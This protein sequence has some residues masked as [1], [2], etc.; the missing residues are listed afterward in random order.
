[1]SHVMRFIKTYR[2]NATK[3]LLPIDSIFDDIITQL[4][5]TIQSLKSCDHILSDRTNHY[6]LHVVLH[7][8]WTTIAVLYQVQRV[9]G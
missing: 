1:M 3:P 2:H 7:V 9:L 8:H 5:N 4:T 6:M